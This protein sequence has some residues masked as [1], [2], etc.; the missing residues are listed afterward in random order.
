M[1]K[2]KGWKGWQRVVISMAV[3]DLEKEETKIADQLFEKAM[4]AFYKNYKSAQRFRRTK[5]FQ[6]KEEKL[7][8]DHVEKLFRHNSRQFRHG[9]Q[10]SQNVDK[11]PKDDDLG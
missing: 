10:S 4:A 3:M 2:F 1:K 5:I 8:I 11:D 6:K 7:A 9:A